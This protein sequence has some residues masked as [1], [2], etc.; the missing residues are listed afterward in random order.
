MVYELTEIGIARH[1]WRV[2]L[3]G[4][5]VR[6][7]LHVF[8]KLD[9]PLLEPQIPR[10]LVLRQLWK[11]PGKMIRQWRLQATPGGNLLAIGYRKTIFGQ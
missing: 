5:R 1:W 6:V 3:V 2:F 11:H 7:V 4:T 10:R 9:Q 8:A